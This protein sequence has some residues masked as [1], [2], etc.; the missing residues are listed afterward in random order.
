MVLLL[1]ELLIAGG[2]RL[3]HFL[4]LQEDPMVLRFCGMKRVP[5]PCT[6]SRWLCRFTR[7]HLDR[8]LLA[9]DKLVAEAVR[10]SKVRRVTFDVDGS[11]VSTGLMDRFVFMI[12]QVAQNE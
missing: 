7:H 5:T 4:F 9:N 6:I 2:C 12:L 11:V 1:L 8:L 10:R 3:R